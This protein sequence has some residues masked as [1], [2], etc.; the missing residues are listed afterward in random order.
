MNDRIG[1]IAAYLTAWSAGT[2]AVASQGD[3]LG[4]GQ[5]LSNLSTAAVLGVAVIF[6]VAVIV[7][8]WRS[9]QKAMALT[10]AVNRVEKGVER[11]AEEERSTRQAIHAHDERQALIGQDVAVIRDRKGS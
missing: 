7:V 10:T 1:H 8:L 6:L 9:V 4:Q 2:L 3:I 5:A 11:L